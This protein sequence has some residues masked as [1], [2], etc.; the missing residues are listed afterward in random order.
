MNNY[1]NKVYTYINQPSCLYIEQRNYLL[2]PLM[3]VVSNISYFQKQTDKFKA[4]TDLVCIYM[5]QQTN[6]IL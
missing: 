3:Y 6:W 4:T 5:K 1:I 2:C